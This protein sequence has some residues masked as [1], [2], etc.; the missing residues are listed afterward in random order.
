MLPVILGAA[1]AIA[2]LIAATNADDLYS[3]GGYGKRTLITSEGA[4][5]LNDRDNIVATTNPVNVNDMTSRSA[6]A[7]NVNSGG[8]QMTIAPSN[9]QINLNLNGAAIGNATARQDYTVGRNI[10]A[11]GGSI[12]YSAPV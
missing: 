2:G 9:T 3:E 4:F 6:G 8:Q 12:D 10:R 11:F 1:G 5:K 7:L